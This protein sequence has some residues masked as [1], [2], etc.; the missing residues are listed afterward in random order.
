MFRQPMPLRANCMVT[1][2]GIRDLCRSELTVEPA[3]LQLE[4]RIVEHGDLHRSAPVRGL[5]DL[6]QLAGLLRSFRDESAHPR[7]VRFR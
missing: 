5:I 6:I 2:L 7:P 1:V 3:L 4:C